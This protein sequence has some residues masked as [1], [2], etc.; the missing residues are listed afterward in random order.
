MV[1]V[2]SRSMTICCEARLHSTV[3]R[4]RHLEKTGANI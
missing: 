1:Y 2:G 4:H 3:N